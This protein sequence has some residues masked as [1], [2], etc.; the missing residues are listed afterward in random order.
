MLMSVLFG[1]VKQQKLKMQEKS[2]SSAF[3]FIRTSER[4]D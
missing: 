3:G 2:K 1:L 4:V